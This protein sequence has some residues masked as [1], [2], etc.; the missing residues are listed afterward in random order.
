MP[1]KTVELEEFELK[2]HDLS[3]FLSLDTKKTPVDRRAEALKRT[4]D[5]SNVDMS[6]SRN[7]DYIDTRVRPPIAETDPTKKFK[8]ISFG[9]PFLTGKKK[10]FRPVE[11]SKPSTFTY[12][13]VYE[14]CGKRF[15]QNLK[16]PDDKVL[17]FIDYCIQFDLK[18]LYDEGLV[19][20]LAV[21]LERE[22]PNF[23]KGLKP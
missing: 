9:I 6:V 16:I 18:K 12:K 23:L 21:L 1:I 4:M 19:L 8:G 11:K 7:D 5:F 20:E 2:R 13:K 15:F 14:L 17:N 22:A 3:G 10:K